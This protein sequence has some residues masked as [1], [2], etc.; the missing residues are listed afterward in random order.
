LSA[1]QR[2]EERGWWCHT[3]RRQSSNI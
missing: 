3:P 2:G 1:T